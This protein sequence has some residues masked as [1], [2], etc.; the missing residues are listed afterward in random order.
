MMYFVLLERKKNCTCNFK[1]IVENN[2]AFLRVLIKRH[3]L[4]LCC[5]AHTQLDGLLCALL[6][7]N[8][9]KN[10][11]TFPRMKGQDPSS[12]PLGNMTGK[13]RPWSMSKQ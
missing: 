5:C 12:F 10:R 2:T 8:N 4:C 11:G 9:Q 1:S 13:L 3:V 7:F 6:L